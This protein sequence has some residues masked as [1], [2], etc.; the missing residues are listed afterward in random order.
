MSDEESTAKDQTGW[1]FIDGVSHSGYLADTAYSL[2]LKGGGS[3]LTKLG[4]EEQDRQVS[5]RGWRHD[6][7]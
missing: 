1:R 5:S 2:V 7:R 6:A 3:Q 4:M